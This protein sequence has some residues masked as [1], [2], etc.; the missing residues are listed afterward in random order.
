MLKIMEMTKND[1]SDSDSEDGDNDNDKP[2]WTLIM[3]CQFKNV[4]VYP[5][6]Q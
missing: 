5:Q 2:V 4:L 3:L 6:G 1:E